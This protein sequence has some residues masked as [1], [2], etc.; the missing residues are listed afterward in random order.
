MNAANP[1]VLEHRRVLVVFSGLLLVLLLAAL[2]STIVATA[3][4]TIVGELGGLERLAWVVTA[5]LLAQTIATPLYGKLG[6]LYGRKVVLQSGIVLFL[7]GSALCGISRTMWQ[8]ILFRFI[9]GL[10]GGGLTVTTQAV[11]GDI[12]SPRERGRYQGI[13]GAVFGLA[14][15][16]GPLLGG[17]FTTH[18]SWRW[19]FYINLPLGIAALSVLAVTLPARAERVTHA[20]DYVGAALLAVAL[21]A[22][23][24]VTDLGGTTYPWGS[25]V[26]VALIAVA[27][28]AL[29][30]FLLAERRAAEPVLPLELFRDRTFALTS[31]IG[32]VVGFA[33]FGSVTYLP[34]F[35]QV[36]KGASPTGSGLQMVP[37]MG[38]LLVTSIL[39]GQL[40]S[41]T[42]RYRVFPIVGT[43]VMAIG[44]FLLSRMG[45]RTSTPAALGIMLVLGLGLGMVTQV[46]VVAVQNAVPYRFLGVAT[47]GATLFRLVGGS[48]GTAMLGAIF[49]ARLMHNLAALLPPERVAAAAGAGLDPRVLASL[50]PALRALYAQAFTAALSDVF[51]VATGV[52]VVGFV[53]TWFVPELPLRATV[54][55][56]AGEVGVEAGETFPMPVSDDSV[57]VLLQGLAA[58][59]DRDVQREYIQTI[60][61]RAGV[62]LSPA[63]AWLL[64]R[65]EHEPGLDPHALGRSKGVPPERIDAALDQLHRQGLVV[66]RRTDGRLRREP[67]GAG[68]DVLARL[69]DS[70]RAHLADAIGE[71]APERRAEVAGVLRRLARALVP[72]APRRE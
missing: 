16:A 11:V 58:I 54:A 55:A 8:L 20:V 26:I 12:V 52:A 61:A 66:D 53:L 67:T 37:M 9:Q 65:L 47:S 71:W 50:P 29:A 19:I 70:R 35:L 43:A 62:D 6:D 64:V 45:P 15:I 22:V 17:Y 1:P 34:L 33:L 23:I 5:Y 32:L 14:S 2:D 24:L 28:L 7:L 3:L 59:A 46:L 27:V 63:A 42:G 13:F 18:L 30:G 48:L 25:P 10:G 38:G 36:V 4:P 41:R 40:I 39:S 21:S 31:A 57:P 44:L 49:A 51:L 60:V 72:E 68:C 56:A 69:V